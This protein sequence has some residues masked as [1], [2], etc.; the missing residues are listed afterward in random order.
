MVAVIKA[1]RANRPV[2]GG[3]VR[4]PARRTA[5][6]RDVGDVDLVVVARAGHVQGKPDVIAVRCE[7]LRPALPQAGTH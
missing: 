1:R 3:E 6:D 4:A 7:C 5:A 2:A